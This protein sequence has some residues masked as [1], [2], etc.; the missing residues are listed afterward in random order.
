MKPHTKSP[1]NFSEKHLNELTQEPTDI[2]ESLNHPIWGLRQNR[3]N[4]DEEAQVDLVPNSGATA[5][6]SLALENRLTSVQKNDYQRQAVGLDDQNEP[7]DSFQTSRK[8]TK[9]EFMT[10]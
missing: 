5:R 2:R 9:A 3:W 4:Q 8:A 1:H 10:Q 7:Q 6:E